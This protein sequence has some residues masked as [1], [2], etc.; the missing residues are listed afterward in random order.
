MKKT[1]NPEALKNLIKPPVPWRGNNSNSH[2]HI[3][4]WKSAQAQHRGVEELELNCD[5]SPIDC[6]G[7]ATIPIAMVTSMD[8]KV[9]RHNTGGVEELN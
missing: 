2:G 3:H 8:G 7:G 9:R 5:D 6:P 1:S 4:G